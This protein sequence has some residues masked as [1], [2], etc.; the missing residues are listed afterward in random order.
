[1]DRNRGKI[2]AAL[3]LILMI[4]GACVVSGLRGLVKQGKLSAGALVTGIAVFLILLLI[5]I[6]LMVVRAFRNHSKHLA[7]SSSADILAEIIAMGE[8]EK[9]AEG[10]KNEQEG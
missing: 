3:L 10:E 9:K 8:Q 7:Q 5:V 1:M 2:L 6:I 4:V